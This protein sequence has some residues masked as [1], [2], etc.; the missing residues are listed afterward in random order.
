MISMRDVLCVP[1]LD[2]NLL[3]MTALNR[4]G[5][6]VVLFTKT[7]V[8]IKKEN[9]LMA[10]GIMRGRKYLL[11]TADTAFYSTEG[12]ETPISG[13]S[14]GEIINISPVAF[15]VPENQ[16]RFLRPPI[17]RKKMPFGYDM[18]ASGMSAQPER[19]C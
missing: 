14:V 4:R 2:A 16:K 13:E 3:S 15:A 17:R 9:T 7:G 8:E 6:A 19:G 10:T 5:L 12:E 11:R 1:G 18:S